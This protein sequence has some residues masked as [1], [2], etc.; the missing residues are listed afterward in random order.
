AVIPDQ[1]VTN[2]VIDIQIIEGELTAIDVSGNDRL[3]SGYISKRIALG[4][5]PPLNIVKLGER[6]QILQQDPRIERL[7]AAL[8]P[9]A[10]PG[11]SRL[12]VEVT[13]ARPYELSIGYDNHQ[14]PS[15]GGDEARI[16]GIDRNLTGFGDTFGFEYDEGQG[17]DEWSVD[18]ALPVDRHD[19]TLALYYSSIES[20]VVSDP[21]DVLDI[22][23]TEET[24]SLS[25]ARPL[26]LSVNRTLTPGLS[27]DLRRNR[28]YLLGEPF[29]FTTGTDDGKTRLSVVRYSMEWLDRGRNKVLAARS[30]L[31]AGIDAFGATVNGEPRDGKFIAWLGQF[32][33]ARRIADSDSQFIFR[34][35]A[36]A[37]NGGLPSIEQYA[38][39]GFDTVRGYREN[40]LIGDAG[41]TASMEARI[42][43]YSNA[44]GAFHLQLV[45]FI[46]YGQVRERTDGDIS[47]DNISSAGIGLLGSLFG[48]IDMELYYGYPFRNFDDPDDDLQDE[49]VTFSLTVRIL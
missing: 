41:L 3:R 16:R 19:T 7:N 1:Q 31:S 4:A 5:G 39:G 42:P 29:A 33:W 49:G 43:V 38:I 23:G 44:S 20:N 14:P 12:D 30:L 34:A 18:Y 11:E 10:R 35:S 48:R 24:W 22:K 9:G 40:R 47:P 26:H 13:E 46:D 36:Q 2:D 27:L 25:I 15:V 45:P 17:L 21:F 32:Q 28:T 8:A 37:A 6:L